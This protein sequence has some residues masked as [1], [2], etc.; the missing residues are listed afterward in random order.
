MKSSSSDHLSAIKKLATIFETAASSRPPLNT[1][2][3]PQPSSVQMSPIHVPQPLT[4]PFS[5]NS[6]P[7]TLTPGPLANANIIAPMTIPYNESEIIPP[8][9]PMLNHHRPSTHRY[10]TRAGN[11]PRHL[12]DCVLKEHTVNMFMIP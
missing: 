2:N 1:K 6:T 8:K 5:K 3:L 7:V 4:Q 12:I 9:P 11:G 10:P